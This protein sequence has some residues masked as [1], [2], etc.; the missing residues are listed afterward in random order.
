[1]GQ[2]APLR[3]RGDAFR[4]RLSRREGRLLRLGASHA[5]PHPRRRPRVDVALHQGGADLYRA[6]R[7]PCADFASLRSERETED[8]RIVAFVD[9]LDEPRLAAPFTYTPI[10]NP[11]PVTQP[12]SPALAH[13]FNH[14]THHR[15]QV[16][17]LITALAG[18][19]AAPP[20]DLI[21]FQRE[22]GSGFPKFCTRGCVLGAV[23]A[24]LCCR[25]RSRAMARRTNSANGISQARRLR[26]S[27]SVE[28]DRHDDLHTHLH[29]PGYWHP[30]P[31]SAN[32]TGV[33]AHLLTWA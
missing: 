24:T 3:R 8:R 13:F 32:P 29:S 1:M 25:S 9:G 4:R 23:E 20:L 26:P 30:H 28:I 2:P 22:T 10:T 33:H 6:R 16:H 12:L 18:R 11:A 27:A 19:D 5:E 15:G 31:T 7:R 17:G 21:Y 14:Q